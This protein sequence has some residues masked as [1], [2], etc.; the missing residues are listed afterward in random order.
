MSEK[1]WI[2]FV[3]ICIGAVLYELVSRQR[4]VFCVMVGHEE[5]VRQVR[6]EINPESA[7][8]AAAVAAAD[9]EDP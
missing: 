6:S 2:A 1:A 8:D 5:V 4:W 7:G 3:W 9:E